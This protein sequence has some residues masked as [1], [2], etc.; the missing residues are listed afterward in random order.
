M[1]DDLEGGF[2]EFE[3]RGGLFSIASDKGVRRTKHLSDRPHVV[4]C[5][6]VAWRLCEQLGGGIVEAVRAIKLEP[7]SSALKVSNDVS[8]MWG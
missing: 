5:L 6:G 8:E 1:S 2:G 4:G 7:D 3:H